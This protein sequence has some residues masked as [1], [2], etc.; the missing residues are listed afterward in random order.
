M[1]TRVLLK[2]V[3]DDNYRYISSVLHKRICRWYSLHHLM[4]TNDIIFY[5][6]Y[7]QYNMFFYGYVITTP[8][9]GKK[10]KITKQLRRL[11]D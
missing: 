5:D 11:I 3:F 4:S 1:G 9:K 2:W 8:M 10:K 7:I 6:E